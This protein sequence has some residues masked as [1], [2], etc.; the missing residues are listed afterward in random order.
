MISWDVIYPGLREAEGAMAPGQQRILNNS[1]PLSNIIIP[2]ETCTLICK[3][4][5]LYTIPI[6][7]CSAERTFSKLARIKNN[8][9]EN[10]N[11]FMVLYT[12]SDVLGI[13]NKVL[14]VLILQ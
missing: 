6:A 12:E 10:L 3:D 13:L 1:R 7:N 8:S 5:N 4:I 2:K 9:Q 11:S 14:N